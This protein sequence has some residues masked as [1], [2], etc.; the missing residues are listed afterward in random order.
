MRLILSLLLFLLPI[1]SR[2]EQVPEPLQPWTGWVLQ[3]SS[4]S[5]CP[6]LYRQSTQ[7]QCAW[8]GQLNLALNDKEGRFEQSWELYD[9][10]DIPLPGNREHWPQQVMVNGVPALLGERD[11]KPVL[12]LPAGEHRINGVWQWASMPVSLQLAPGT[13]LLAL[14]V[15]GQPVAEPE[16]DKQGRLWPGRRNQAQTPAA[17][18]LNM[19]V[20]RHIADDIPLQVNT[21]IELKVA[22]EPRELQLGPVLLEDQ[23]PLAL[24]S[25]LPARLM[26]D[27]RLRLQI[28]PGNWQLQLISRHTGPAE[29]LSLPA[30]P[31]PWPKEEVWV[32]QA[33]PQL[34]VMEING[35]NA[36]DAGQ[37]GLPAHWQSLPAFYMTPG[38]TMA[39]TEL[40]RGDPGPS[41][42]PLSLRRELWLDFNGGGY[43]VNDTLSGNLSHSIRLTSSL[44]PGRI[45]VNGEPRPVT[46]LNNSQPGIELRPGPVELVADSRQTNHI[47]SLPVSG[48]NVTTDNV[49][50]RLNL[51]PGWS[52]LAAFGMDNR[53]HT[54]LQ[55]WT[56]LDLF[57]VLIAAVAALRLWGWHW[58]MLTLVTLGLIW[59]QASGLGPPRWIWLH[60]LAAAALLRVLP[61]NRLRTWVAGYRLLAL[62]VLTLLTIPFMVDEVRTALYPQLARPGAVMPAPVTGSPRQASAEL[63]ARAEAMKDNILSA[64]GAPDALPRLDPNAQ[65]QTGPG[66]PDWHWRTL[67]F[68]W[69][70]PVTPEQQLHLFL[71]SPKVNAGLNLLRVVLLCL[72]VLRM[73]G[74]SLQG[75]KSLY[76]QQKL[77]SWPL[78]LLMLPLL[79]AAPGAKAD[80]PSPELLAELK[81]RLQAP[82]DCLPECALATDLTLIAEPDTLILTL[83]IHTQTPMAVPL[84]GRWQPKQVQLNST[85]ASGLWRNGE[86]VLHLPL[87]AGI[88]RIEMSGPLPAQ[89]QLQLSLPMPPKRVNARLNGWR[90][91]GVNENGVPE[92]RLQ[93]TRLTADGKPEG[94][95]LKPGVLPNFAEL[96]RTLQLG[97]DW[98][99]E[100]QLVRQTNVDQTLR[101]AIPLLPG[102]SVLTD[103]IKVE[104][105]KALISLASGQRQL[106]WQSAL[107]RTDSL[108]LTATNTQ[109]WSETWRLDASPI[110]H[111]NSDGLA[112]VH[113]QGG[114]LPEWRPWPGEQLTLAISRP[115]TVPGQTLTIDASSLKVQPG[116]HAT[117]AHLELILRSS[118]GGRHALQLPESAELQRVEINGRTLPLRLSERTLT[119]PLTP[120]TQT[121]RIHWRQPAGIGPVFTTLQ[122]NLNSPSVNH[123][124]ELVPGQDRWVLF[125]GGPRL[126]PAVLFWSLLAITALLAAGLAR[127]P[128]TP[129]RFYHWLLLGLGL[130]QVPLWMAATV[131]L[132][133]LALGLRAR[134]QHQQ[135]GGWFNLAQIG[136]VLLTLVAL[137]YLFAAIQQGLLGLPDM[138]IA[139]NGS[140]GNRLNWYQDRSAATLPTGWMLSVPLLVYRL[141]MLLWALWLAFALL[142][143]LRWGWECFASHGLWR[144][145]EFF[146]RA[147]KTPWKTPKKPEQ[148]S[149]EI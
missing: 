97:L 84:P 14:S 36:V 53:P 113:P 23:I 52:L 119:L 142:G 20:Y 35:P 123:R 110:W 50:S 124:I 43:T 15:N 34:R 30:T 65:V 138:Q 68:E 57:L 75:G 2:A 89:S 145:L 99:I 86:G 80:F 95:A 3:G 118:Q 16:L 116:K 88:H 69:N 22:G 17:N 103:G 101:L 93:L 106:S 28:R 90:L 143:W 33:F 139:G 129:L 64:S 59:H 83:N 31:T 111:V 42:S 51:P 56:L 71:L 45:T 12:S 135:A 147:N 26:P 87:P 78:T 70:G 60:L 39:F 104:N 25:P 76:L 149:D 94:S 144:P 108:V 131:V 67:E 126:G 13:G 74:F 6:L 5:R 134:W 10:A 132:W 117:D 82:P 125:T 58:G 66:L 98:R 115:A 72:L 96:T 29:A 105:G 49:S 21:H 112:P 63:E 32:V 140:W 122:V 9:D 46:Q 100:N 8:P 137:S 4:Q 48:W 148:G 120:G 47:G 121:A 136:L 107:A 19:T 41:Q 38:T 55:R 81:T 114:A 92:G 130:T 102:E 133:L 54:W 146:R 109:D 141:L 18:T 24:N 127:L 11:G 61:A 7:R 79:L 27:G 85:A 40:R 128:F 91:Q 37:S 73:A 62:L 1:L 77:W 44:S